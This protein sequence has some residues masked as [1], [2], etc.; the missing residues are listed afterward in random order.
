LATADNAKALLHHRLDDLQI[1]CLV[2][3]FHY[4]LLRD[5]DLERE[6]S[7]SKDVFR[8]RIVDPGSRHNLASMK[9]PRV[10]IV[11]FFFVV[12]VFPDNGGIVSTGRLHHNGTKHLCLNRLAEMDNIRV[13]NIPT[14]KVQGQ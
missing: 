11:V 6:I 3:G 4:H 10:I 1:Q 7:R 2:G 5:V 14:F 8:L 13:G 12:A 9:R